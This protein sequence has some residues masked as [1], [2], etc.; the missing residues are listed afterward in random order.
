MSGLYSSRY[1]VHTVSLRG[2]Q[3]DRLAKSLK[4]VSNRNNGQ[5]RLPSDS[6]MTTISQLLETIYGA[7][8]RI[9]KKK[10]VF[11]VET[12]G[13]CYVAVT[14]LPKPQEQHAVIMAKFAAD[15]MTALSGMMHVLVEKLGSD[16]ANLSMRFGLHSV[17]SRNTICF[18]NMLARHFI[19][20]N[21]VHSLTTG[22]SYRRSIER[23]SCSLSVV[24]RY[25]QHCVSHGEQRAERSDS[26]EQIYR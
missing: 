9:A 26:S 11:K 6:Y 13:D 25:C 18:H 12:I 20:S 7:F 5:S 21:W 14:G 4:Y 8:D 3:R 22:T 2:L 23:R 16:T 17:S 15:C 19:L 1:L 24:W 10:N